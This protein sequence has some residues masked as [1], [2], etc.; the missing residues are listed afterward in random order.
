MSRTLG[1]TSSGQYPGRRPSQKRWNGAKKT[2]GR[3]GNDWH[4]PNEPGRLGR[5]LRSRTVA[6]G[7]AADHIRIQFSRKSG[8]RR[9]VASLAIHGLSCHGN[10]GALQALAAPASEHRHCMFPVAS[11]SLRGHFKL[12]RGR[13]VRRG[14]KSKRE[15]KKKARRNTHQQGPSAP[16]PPLSPYTEGTLYRSGDTRAMHTRQS[17]RLLSTTITTP[18]RWVATSLADRSP[19]I[20]PGMGDISYLPDLHMYYVADRAHG[21]YA[22]GMTE[23]AVLPVRL[24]SYRWHHSHT[25]PDTHTHT[26][27]LTHTHART[28]AHTTS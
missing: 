6:S 26:H 23:P 27:T 19:G 16:R 15:E 3:R 22:L 10:D 28:H 21:L 18:P 25:H 14:P 7:P 24:A 11:Q 1:T 12:Q 2:G 5:S 20:D 4:S 9:S 13:A 17:T 8:A